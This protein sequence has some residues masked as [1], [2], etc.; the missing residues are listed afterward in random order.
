M[1][2]NRV[3]VRTY[4]VAV[5]VSLTVTPVFIGLGILNG[6]L[7]KTI[8]WMT[9]YTLVCAV[10]IRDKAFQ[11]AIVHEYLR[12]VLLVETLKIKLRRK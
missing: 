2:M 1:K 6:E 11:K 8:G 7:L 10:A 3:L 4:M 9:M 5:V 12:L